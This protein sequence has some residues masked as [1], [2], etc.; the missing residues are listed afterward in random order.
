MQTRQISLSVVLLLGALLLPGAGAAQE[1]AADAPG[2]RAR[3][4]YE[5]FE[6]DNGLRLIVSED[7]S[8]PVAAVDVWYHV[9]SRH[10]P[11]DRS[12][13]AHLFEHMMF[14]G[15]RHVGE[16]E[17]T[18]HMALIQGVGG[19]LNGSTA[20]DRTNYFQTVPANRV[21]LALWLEADRMRFLDV[22]AENFENQ[23]EV[24]KEERRQNY[25]NRP[26]TLAFA[27]AF[28]LPYDE[29]S[30]FPYSRMGI[31]SMEDLDA[32]TL[33]DVRSFYETY[34]APN[35]AVVAVAGDVE[36]AHVREMAE[37]YFEGAKASALPPEEECRVDFDAGIQ[38]DTIRDPNASLPAVFWTFRTPPHA[39]EDTYALTLL[40]SILGQGESSRLHRALVQDAGAAT[41]AT[42]FH[43]ENGGWRKGPGLLG[44]YAF[45]NQGIEPDSLRSLFWKEIEG[46]RE[47]P[48]T[49]EEVEKAKNSFEADWIMGRQTVLE[50]AETLH[51]FALYHDDLADVNR[52]LDRFLAVTR[53]DLQRVI[54]RYL[55][56][57]NLTV[58][59]DV[60][61]QASA[62]AD[63][64]DGDEG[65]GGGGP[66][67]DGE[68][69]GGGADDDGARSE[70]E[71]SRR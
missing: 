52:A 70:G 8:T 40:A 17:Q 32:A 37:D 19:S 13:F 65:G 60:P 5:T 29:E 68:A 46:L 14:E 15:S 35:N 53:D 62:A 50:K 71:E 61:A 7:R 18:T 25:E 56:R 10:D 58:V 16:T 66:P 51:H 48:P 1:A 21:N 49:A 4:D 24:V 30:C 69:D 45:A 12:G 11:R 31:G 57:D 55:T 28:V 64:G 42:A 27:T 36:T 34:Y 3:I 59:V 54:D 9:G 63:G 43:G 44:A 20:D 47:R 23:R 67:D 26:Y 41:Q 2:T 22:T 33:D 38:V 6:L 39:H